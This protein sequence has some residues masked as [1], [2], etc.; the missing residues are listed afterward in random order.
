MYTYF[1]A[2][3]IILETQLLQSFLDRDLHLAKGETI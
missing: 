3:V 1:G 2:E